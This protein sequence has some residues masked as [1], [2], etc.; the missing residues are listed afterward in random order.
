MPIHTISHALHHAHSTPQWARTI[1]LLA[2]FS[3]SARV[4]CH[5]A[6]LCKCKRPFLWPACVCA[7]PCPTRTRLSFELSGDGDPFRVRL[8]CP[9][10][11]P[12]PGHEPPGYRQPTG[13]LPRIS[14]LFRVWGKFRLQALRE[15]R[16]PNHLLGVC[17]N[18]GHICPPSTLECMAIKSMTLIGKLL[19][20]CSIYNIIFSFIIIPL[21]NSCAPM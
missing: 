13:L 18:P 8:P 7:V 19:S 5:C 10:A 3:R 17:G 14:A 6:C 1:Q 20:P 4:A 15:L 9:K 11:H 12:P 21:R 16:S 2:L